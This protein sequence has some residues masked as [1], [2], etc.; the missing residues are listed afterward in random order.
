ME[1]L[2]LLNRTILDIY[3]HRHHYI[4]GDRRF[5]EF[6]DGIKHW[7]LNGKLHRED[8]PAVVG[9]SGIKY[10]YINGQGLSE[11]EFNN[12]KREI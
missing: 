4:D 12:R 3:G 11:K 10:Y 1:Q 7:Y 5:V 8:G 9:L 6:V 2:N